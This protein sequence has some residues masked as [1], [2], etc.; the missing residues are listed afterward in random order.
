MPL[1]LSCIYKKINI[2]RIDKS[3]SPS[4]SP[5][6]MSPVENEETKNEEGEK[7]PEIDYQ[8]AAALLSVKNRV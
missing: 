2:V 1:P 5:V 4:P 3:K 7:R 6:S 8:A